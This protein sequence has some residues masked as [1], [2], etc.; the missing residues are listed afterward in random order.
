M[1][2]GRSSS[3]TVYILTVVGHFLLGKPEAEIKRLN[4]VLL[5]YITLISFSSTASCQSLT[6]RMSAYAVAS[7]K[8]V[9]ECEIYSRLFIT[10]TQYARSE[11]Y[12]LLK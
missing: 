2:H 6:Y 12:F 8:A 5:Q 3:V 10:K 7:F 9:K 4:S 1:C 11:L